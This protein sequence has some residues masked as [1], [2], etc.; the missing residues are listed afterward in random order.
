MAKKSKKKRAA[1]LTR[2]GER[3]AELSLVSRR[4]IVWAGLT[5]LI[6]LPT[7][8]LGAGAVEWL[9][10]QLLDQVRAAHPDPVIE[11]VDLP[12]SMVRIA[13][14]DLNGALLPVLDGDWLDDH[15]CQHIARRLARVGWVKNV[16]FVRRSSDAKFRIS[17]DYRS[18]FAMVQQGESF[19][20][21]DV[22]GVRLP[23]I[24]GYDPAWPVIQGVQAN[25]PKEGERWQG[26][27]VGAGVALLAAVLSEPFTQQITAAL[28]GNYGGRIDPKSSHVELATDRMGGRIRWGS[29]P[30]EEIEENMM[31]QKL[32]IL[33]QNYI[34]TGRVDA[35]HA[36]VDV[37]TFPDRFT[38]PG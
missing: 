38:V 9:D 7:T 28:V 10:K 11:F 4:R 27:D 37:S 29:A 35:G 30:G 19:S 20:L 16:Y 23:G 34:R 33:R 24:Y 36:V 12:P 1:L 21:V 6:I 17:C 8:M 2:I 31:G 3:L 13:G 18:P 15:V 25:A 5:V 14:R 32:A 26:R 22:E